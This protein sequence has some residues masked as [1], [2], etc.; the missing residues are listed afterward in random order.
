MTV[1]K[2]P[3]AISGVREIASQYDAVFVDQFGVL[4]D[5]AAAFP[6]AIDAL[7]R[8]TQMGKRVVLLSNSGK[9]SAPNE[10]RLKK[11]GFP[12]GS[13]THFLSSGE[14]G[15]SILAEFATTH[16]V[17]QRCLLIARDQDRSAIEGLP[18]DVTTDGAACDLVVI[19][20]SEG[21]A[22]TL[23]EYAT[24]LAPAA[25]RG[26]RAYCTNPDKEMLT[27]HGLRFGAGRIAMLYEDLG[28]KV[29]WIGKPF[30]EIYATAQQRVGNVD[31][32]RILCI[33]DSVEHDIAGASRA[34]LTSWL[35]CSGIH[36]GTDD[37]GLAALYVRK[38]AAPDYISKDFQLHFAFP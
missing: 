30:P 1:I 18:L 10:A 22:R 28:G 3:R 12:D 29:I 16:S 35:I 20:A 7:V 19:A 6:R 36:E 31:S 11:L 2:S 21:E 15:W 4:H 38:G 26:V 13:W 33:G 9:R 34:A 24:L 32:A 8:L 14:L 25:R 5:G 27:P 17:R 23:D 37:V